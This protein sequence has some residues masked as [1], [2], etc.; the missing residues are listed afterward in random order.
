MPRYSIEPRARKYDIGYRFLSIAKNLCDKY[1]KYLLETA[2]KTKLN[3]AKTASKKVF[4]N[5]A[6]ATRELIGNTIVEKM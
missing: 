6:E 5:T 4:H 1:G 2:T 3:Y